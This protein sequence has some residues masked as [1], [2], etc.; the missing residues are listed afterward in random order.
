[1]ELA[2]ILAMTGFVAGGFGLAGARPLRRFWRPSIAV[3]IAG[4]ATV[5]ATVRQ[6]ELLPVLLFDV[7]ALAAFYQWTNVAEDARFSPVVPS[8]RWRRFRSV[9]GSAL[10]LLVT[11]FI[12]M[13]AVSRSWH[14]QWGVTRQELDLVF[15]A[16]APSATPHSRSTMALPS[17][18]HWPKCGHGSCS[19]AEIE[20]AC[21]ATTRSR[22]CS[23]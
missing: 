6:L 23:V 3:A 21:T 16:I 1:M 18:R 20:P 8:T 17:T 5:F 15:R 14:S 22:T 10:A 19:S 9:A 13:C 11:A 4:S 12:A 2:W 7:L